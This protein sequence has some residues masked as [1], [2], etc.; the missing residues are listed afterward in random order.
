VAEIRS[1]QFNQ[2]LIFA[3][4]PFGLPDYPMCPKNPHAYQFNPLRK[5]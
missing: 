1:T 5:H 3:H 2:G 4:L